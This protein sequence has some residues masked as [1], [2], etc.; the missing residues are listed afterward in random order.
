MHLHVGSQ[1]V[2]PGP[3]EDAARAALAL[4]HASAERGA[5]LAQINLGGGFGVDY[6]RGEDAFPLERHAELLR[7]IAAGQPFEWRFEP[8]RWLVAPVGVLVAEVL[9]VKTR[10]EAGEPRRFVV[11]AAGMNDLIRPALYGA[12]HRIVPVRPRA[13]E[14][15]P[16]T[17]VGPVCESGDTFAIERA[18]PPLER[19]DLVAILDA[20]AYGS[21][22]SSNYNGR[23]RL[24]EL[25]LDRGVLRRARAGETPEQLTAR[26]S[27]DVLS[28]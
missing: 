15:S 14:A 12:H 25:A 2:E 4:A 19:G 21:A 13:G 1:I 17:V 10:L 8:G 27:G 28:P 22:M 9:W 6:E 23:G 3:L 5:P 11:L 18:L 24:A 20:G 26:E 16:T 7:A